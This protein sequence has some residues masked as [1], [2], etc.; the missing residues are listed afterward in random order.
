MSG[1]LEQDNFTDGM[2]EDI[3]TGHRHTW[4]EEAVFPRLA[5]SLSY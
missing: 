3:V 4:E 2:A 5:G 1:D